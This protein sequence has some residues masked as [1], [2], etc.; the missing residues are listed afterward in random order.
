MSQGAGQDDTDAG[1]FDAKPLED[2]AKALVAGDLQGAAAGLVNAAA[3]AAAGNPF[4]G[5]V[6]GGA[7]NWLWAKVAARGATARLQAAAKPELAALGETEQRAWMKAAAI[8]AL[9]QVRA[10][11]ATEAE[12]AQAQA[13][14]TELGTQAEPR[15]QDLQ[16][17]EGTLE[18]GLGQALR[19][20]ADLKQD[21]E[22]L[23][24]DHAELKAAHGLTHAQLDA[25]QAKLDNPGPASQP[26]SVVNIHGPVTFQGSALQTGANAQ[27]APAGAAAA[28]APAPQ[29]RAEGDRELSRLKA[30]KKRLVLEGESTT[31]LDQQI[32]E[33]R[34]ELRNVETVG[35]G[36]QLYG[37]RFEVQARIGKGGFG[38]VW[39]AYDA[40]TGKRV[41]VKALHHQFQDDTT[42]RERFFRGAKRM[43]AL[44]HPG[45]VD[46]I[47]TSGREDEPP[48]FV[49]EYVA[50]GDLAAQV[51]KHGKW[52]PDR[53]VALLLSLGEALQYAHE[54][55]Q[56]HRDVKPA[57]ILLT[58]ECSPKLTDFDLVKAADT[59]GGT[60]TG[61]LGTFL[62]APPEALEDA[63][64]V[65]GR[66]DIYS[67]AMVGVFALYGRALNAAVLRDSQRFITQRLQC[68]GALRE[69]LIRACAWEPT[70]RHSDMEGLLI[71]LRDGASA[72]V[73]QV[74]E[75]SASVGLGEPALPASSP[76]GVI[77]D[78]SSVIVTDNGGVELVPIPGGTF[79]MGSPES[80]QGRFAR[81]G[82]QHNVQVSPFLLGRYPVTNEE[83]GRFLEANPDAPKPLEWSAKSLTHHARHPVV[84]VSWEQAQ[85]FCQWAGGHLPTEAEWEYACRAGTTESRYGGLSAVAWHLGNS[86]EILH[87]VGERQ[88][89]AWGLHDM[90]GNVWEWCADWYGRYSSEALTDPSG[91]V[92]GD[93]RVVRGGC[94]RFGGR[95]ARS[96]YR[97]A[98][99]PAARNGDLGFRLSRGQNRSAATRNGIDH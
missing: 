59:T 77:V 69:T 12:L 51:C 95:L 53:T 83:Y 13:L 32:L 92:G 65:D 81:E 78:S 47:V 64:R 44:R 62:Y 45:I 60:R 73:A 84:G 28:Q 34:R 16:S 48:Y 57:N 24:G 49:M 85:R 66:A 27:F 46:V 75:G 72:V 96:A 80:E 63:S 21:H 89:N 93:E 82:P 23:E 99:P 42:R 61:A 94:W 39:L 26:G 71:E 30:E 19:R 35:A 7:A 88:P 9:Q 41:A 54:Q 55:G 50:G 38:S 25:V 20:L 29:P 43:A 40:E 1:G 87:F 98:N 76:P 33:R 18:E 79:T 14:A 5:I 70:E 22:Q 91:P 2:P 86:G 52:S 36:T 4:A 67:L 56:V 15:P 31:D 10:Q 6:V 11:H 3:T 58:A 17:I 97:L 37:G 68:S 8:E 90:L 74:H